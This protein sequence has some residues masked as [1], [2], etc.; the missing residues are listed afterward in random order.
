MRMM[1]KEESE[2]EEEEVKRPSGLPTPICSPSPHP[3]QPQCLFPPHSNLSQV[4]HIPADGQTPDPVLIWGRPLS[5]T[6]EWLQSAD[7]R[8]KSKEEEDLE[9]HG[10]VQASKKEMQKEEAKKEGQNSQSSQDAGPIPALPVRRRLNMTPQSRGQRKGGDPPT[11]DQDPDPLILTARYGKA[12]HCSESCDY[13]R[14]P[15]TGM[16]KRSVF[17][18]TCAS[19][20]G[21]T[22]SMNLWMNSWGPQL[23]TTEHASTC[24]KMS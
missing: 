18:T 12:F 16:T 17:C 4:P 6:E 21:K 2:E 10:Q 20:N 23:T 1:K 15:W 14:A 5:S 8:K 7:R 3:T 24:D 22:T 9:E 13:V 11:A 19:K